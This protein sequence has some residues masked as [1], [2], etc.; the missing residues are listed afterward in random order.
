M[1]L[2]FSGQAGPGNC[3]VR[4]SS[5]SKISTQLEVVWLI[6][7]M[8]MNWAYV[9]STGRVVLYVYLHLDIKPSQSHIL[10]VID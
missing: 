1:L 5:A 10:S 4:S 8:C 7:T 3:V 2:G 6:Y 9:G